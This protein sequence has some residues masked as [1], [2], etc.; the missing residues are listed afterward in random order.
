MR[1]EQPI[2][3]QAVRWLMSARQA[4]RWATTQENAWSIIGLTDWMVQTG[5]L[6]ADYNWTG[7]AQ[8][9]RNGQRHLQRR[10][11]PA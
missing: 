3:P 5:E 6:E 9:G 2:L 11:T 8:R 4:G 10:E 7:H 1:P